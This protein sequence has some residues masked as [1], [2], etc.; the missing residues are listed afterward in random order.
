MR[1][2]PTQVLTWGQERAQTGP[3][4]GRPWIPGARVAH[5]TPLQS[6]ASPAGPH[7]VWPAD[8]LVGTRGAVSL[9]FLRRCMST[10]AGQGY[11]SLVTTALTDP[12]AQP[13]YALGFVDHERLH[14]LTR[15]L[16]RPIPPPP[17]RV[18]SLRGHHRQRVLALDAMAFDDDWRLAPAGLDEA[19]AATPSARLRVVLADDSNPKTVCGYAVSGRAGACGYLQ[20][21]AVH[22]Q[23]RRLGIAQALVADGLRW[24]RRNRVSQA[25]VNTQV[26][27]HGAL[28]LY[29][30]LG[31]SLRPGDLRI[32]RLDFA[33]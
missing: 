28:A 30:R 24:M 6:G 29:Q 7:G 2:A 27:N 10:L 21:L 17:V 13:F 8:D 19:L 20:R 31:F 26:G 33:S 5:L 9:V 16:D 4:T 18:H 14:L 1:G 23:H 22:P 32:L 3:W 11:T 25:M 12:Q 15:N